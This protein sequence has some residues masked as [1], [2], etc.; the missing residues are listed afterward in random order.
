[1][2][3]EQLILFS[4]PVIGFLINIAVIV[5]KGGQLS[6]KIDSMLDRVTK[7]EADKAD[8]LSV[9]HM[10]ENHNHNKELIDILTNRLDKHIEENVSF[11]GEFESFKANL[12]HLS[13][14][15]EELKDMIRELQKR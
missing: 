10:V 3:I 4:I 14:G 9:S 13:R 6:G 5:Y 1:M 11:K 15:Q 12:D 2:N 7:L 8:K